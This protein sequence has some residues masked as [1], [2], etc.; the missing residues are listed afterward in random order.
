MSLLLLCTFFL[1][2]VVGRILM[3]YY[4]TGNHGIRPAK[5]TAPLIEIIPGSVFILSF[6]LSAALI[7]LN[8]F[9]L[10]EFINPL[11][12]SITLIGAGLGF[13]G[14]L[15]TLIAQIQMG[16]SWRIGVDQDEKTAL[17]TSGL[18]AKSRNPIYFGMLLYWI[19]IS[20]NFPHMLMLLCAFICWI[21]IEAIVRKI[22]E[23]Y[24][25]RM[26]GASAET[27]FGKTNRYLPF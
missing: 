3:Q 5:R 16:L 13:L 19:A 8:Y 23:P 6:L 1:L 7:V 24:L 2:A 4:Y 11:P 25:K 14:I 9:G 22:E 12:R 27:Y 15:I 17:I 21:S 20:L 10:F 26:H 18:Y